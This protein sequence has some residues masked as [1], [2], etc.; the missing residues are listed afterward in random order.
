M[1]PWLNTNLTANEFLNINPATLATMIN[2]EQKIVAETDRAIRAAAHDGVETLRRRLIL[3]QRQAINRQNAI[4][5]RLAIDFGAARGWTLSPSSFGLRTLAE[6][7]QH[8]RWQRFTAS[9]DRTNPGAL[10]FFDQFDHPYYYRRDRKAA[11]IAAHLYRWPAVREHY[12]VNAPNQRMRHHI[13][14]RDDM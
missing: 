10:M 13:L 14:N 7:K 9:Y 5:R 1:N 11:A 3:K 4:E 2:D 12:A 6:G 8:G